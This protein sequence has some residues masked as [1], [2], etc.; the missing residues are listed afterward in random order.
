[1]INLSRLMKVLV[2]LITVLTYVSSCQTCISAILLGVW[3]I[4]IRGVLIHSNLSPFFVFFS[5]LL[6]PNVISGLLSILNPQFTSYFCYVNSSNNAQSA[7]GGHGREWQ[8]RLSFAAI[9]VAFAS[10][11]SAISAVS[12]QMLCP[13]LF[14]WSVPFFPLTPGT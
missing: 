10:N 9:S 2:D 14:H 7:T 8:M 13:D 11:Q 4:C 12:P 1:M 3:S 5:F 6:G